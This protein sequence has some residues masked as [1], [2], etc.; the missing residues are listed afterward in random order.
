[1]FRVLSPKDE[2]PPGFDDTSPG[3][4]QD[5]NPQSGGSAGKVY[6]LDAPG[7]HPPSVDGKTYR[8]R[9]N[10]S[11]YAA[12]PDGTQISP[13][14]NFYVRLSCTQ[15]SSGYQFVSDVAGDNQI[16]PGSTKTSWNLQ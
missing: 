16:G 2:K 1:M 6:D 10:F 14:Y 8:S 4:L 15:S 7:V 13:N 9:V 12:L 11:T 3:T 5:E